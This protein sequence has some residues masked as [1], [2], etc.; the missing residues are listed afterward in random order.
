MSGKWREQLIKIIIHSAVFQKVT[1]YPILSSFP[2]TNNNNNK[3]KVALATCTY[4]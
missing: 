1:D 2:F 3:K 4:P